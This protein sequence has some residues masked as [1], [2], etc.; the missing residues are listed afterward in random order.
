MMNTANAITADFEGTALTTIQYQGR[1]AWIANEIGAALG[2][3]RGGKRLV[4]SIT[5]DWG[6]EFANGTDYLVLHGKELRDFKALLTDVTDSVSSKL[7]HSR[8]E[9]MLIFETGLYLVVQKTDKPAGVRLRRFLAEHVLP[10]IRRTGAYTPAPPQPTPMNERMLEEY[11]RQGR[12][13]RITQLLEAGKGNLSGDYVRRIVETCLGNETGEAKATNPILDVSQFLADK[14]F[15]R[16]GQR[17]FAGAFGKTLRRLYVEKHGEEPKKL[18]RY[19]NDHD[20]FVNCYT[21]K[22]RP[23]FEAAFLVHF[24]GRV[25]A[26]QNVPHLLTE[27]V[28]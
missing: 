4:E 20:V 9:M 15:G 8:R 14:G 22:D 1:P 16:E 3:A 13:W 19:V 28:G 11:L 27:E 25:E 2:Y 7:E 24:G 6:Q 5:K 18:Q 23:L 17:R 21:E 12:I 10:Q 26:N